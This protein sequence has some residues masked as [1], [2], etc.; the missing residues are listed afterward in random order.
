MKN[1]QIL[2][3]HIGK[4]E[5]KQLPNGTTVAN[6]TVATSDDYK[7]KQGEWVKVTDWHNIVIFGKSAERAANQ[8]SKGKLVYVEGK[9][10]TR[11]WEVEGGGKKYITEVHSNYF[12]LLE[13]RENNQSF[14][15]ASDAP[16]QPTTTT[17]SASDNMPF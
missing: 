8:L 10:K 11:S 15:T 2:I 16:S 9:S 7:D 4:F 17:P 12:R 14:P 6:F 3:G 13:K 1:L 5:S